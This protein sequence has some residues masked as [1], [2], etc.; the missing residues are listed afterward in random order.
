MGLIVGVAIGVAAYYASKELSK[1]STTYEDGT[2]V[3][4]VKITRR[5]AS[6]IE[7]NKK[8][9]AFAEDKFKN[10]TARKSQYQNAPVPQSY[11]ETGPGRVGSQMLRAQSEE[12]FRN[13][14][15]RRKDLLQ[16]SVEEEPS[17]SA[18]DEVWPSREDPM[19]GRF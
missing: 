1:G 3:P 17:E 2:P 6:T 10:Y 13:R 14:L 16:Q 11:S 18:P 9:Q 4:D 5:P 7:N 8:D 19:I 12:E 15:K